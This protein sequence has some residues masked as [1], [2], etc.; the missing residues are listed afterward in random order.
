MFGEAFDGD[1]ELLGSFTQPT[2]WTRRSYFSRSTSRSIR[3]VFQCEHGGTEGIEQLLQRAHAGTTTRA[4][5]SRGGASAPRRAAAGELLRQPRRAA[6][7]RRRSSTRTPRRAAR[8]ARRRRRLRAHAQKLLRRADLPAHGRRHPLHVLRHRAGFP[9]SERP[10]Q[11]RGHVALRQ[12][13]RP[14]HAVGTQFPTDGA[15]FQ[16]DRSAH[17]HPPR[18][19]SRCARGT[20]QI[21]WITPRTGNEQ[22][23][24]ILAFDANPMEP[25]VLVAINAHSG[26][27]ER[28][29]RAAHGRR[30]RCHR[31]RPWHRARRRPRRLRAHGDRG[32]ERAPEAQPRPVGSRSS[33]PQNQVQTLAP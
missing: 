12:R 28:D 17:A 18:L 23:A 3:D 14:A 4:R 33:V 19:R 15:T 7:P 21:R 30:R 25:G 2:R 32:L 6:L 1:D 8:A 10:V 24:G 26:G 29:L 22:D 31:L 5:R 27:D 16:H 20:F 9:G 13:R 11:P